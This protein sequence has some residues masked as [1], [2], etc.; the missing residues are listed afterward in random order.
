MQLNKNL[1]NKHICLGGTFDNLHVGHRRLISKA[2]EMGKKVTIGISSEKLLLSKKYKHSIEP[3]ENRKSNLLKY[4]NKNFSNC[5]FRI[6][7]LNNLYGSTLNDTS[8]DAIVCSLE[9]LKSVKKI[10]FER[11]KIGL[12]PLKIFKVQLVKN[13]SNK[14]VR[15]TLIRAGHI[16]S[17]GKSY[18]SFFQHKKYALLPNRRQKLR[19]PLGLVFKGDKN[20]YS[21]AVFMAYKHI[22]T[23]GEGPIVTVGDI[24]YL[25]FL[26]IGII[27][28]L[29]VVDN[30][31]YRKFLKYTYKFNDCAI[32]SAGHI[33][34]MAVTK[35]SR[36]LK[37]IS[38]NL[39]ADLLLKIKGEEDL[40]VIPC[41]LLSPI[42]GYVVYGQANKGVIVIK[43][44]LNRKEKILRLFKKNFKEKN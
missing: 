14:V 32:N 2:F 23:A 4:L 18:L 40:L 3:Y 36:L 1:K 13:G 27:P 20:N 26:K 15:S 8:L 11:V 37:K 5:D 33:C 41:V 43:V 9:T 6:I 44:T 28:T 35:I 10:N 22:K 19:R 30:K 24:V 31:N 17:A 42:G 25:S 7:P 21:E 12:L 29:A 16:N 39:N 34:K 38:S